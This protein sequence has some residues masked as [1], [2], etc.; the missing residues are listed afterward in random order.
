MKLSDLKPKSVNFEVCGVHL[1]FRPF[2]IADDLA[3]EEIAGNYLILQ[4][5]LEK[6][7]FEKLSLLAWYQLDIKSQREVLKAI[8]GIYID[9]ETG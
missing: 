4:E 7:D 3:S 1:T 9:P 8:E 2:I 5:S 6:F